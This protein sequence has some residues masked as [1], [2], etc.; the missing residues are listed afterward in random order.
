MKQKGHHESDLK[1]PLVRELRHTLPYF[2]I[3]RHEDVRTCGIPDLSVTGHKKTTWWEIK[4]AIPDYPSYGLQELT[5]QRL[6]A[7]GYCRYI[8]YWEVGGQKRTLI[9]SPA[10][11]KVP[12]AFDTPEAECP[13][14]DH[15][16]VTQFIE[17]VHLRG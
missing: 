2:V 4:N 3:Q 17:R 7:H 16:W 1:S 14:H 9:V 8:I 5:C 15:K 13:G 12:K 10:R 6:E 11:L